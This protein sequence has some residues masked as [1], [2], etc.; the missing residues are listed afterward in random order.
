M[1]W[2]SRRPNA[3]N[4]SVQSK[5]HNMKTRSQ[6]AKFSSSSSSEDEVLEPLKQSFKT[7][8]GTYR[9]NLQVSKPLTRPPTN[10]DVSCLF[11]IDLLPP[12]EKA[13]GP[14]SYLIYSRPQQQKEKMKS[15][16]VI[17]W[18][19]YN[20]KGIRGSGTSTEMVSW[21]MLM[22]NGCEYWST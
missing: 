20:G 17:V 9:L 7:T 6:V 16:L 11:Q 8:N 21:W 19:N 22:E 15:Q 3:W 2:Y 13:D 1:E 10:F 5:T 12:L 4:N 18:L 14:K